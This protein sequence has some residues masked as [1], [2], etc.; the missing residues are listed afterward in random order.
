[1]PQSEP[2]KKKSFFLAS[3]L[4]QTKWFYDHKLIKLLLCNTLP[5]TKVQQSAAVKV[6]APVVVASMTQHQL[7]PTT[8]V[9]QIQLLYTKYT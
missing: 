3:I 5:H 6:A 4:G 2:P 7:N 9:P 8:K 1:M